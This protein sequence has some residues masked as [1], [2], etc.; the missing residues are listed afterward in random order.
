MRVLSRARD[1]YRGEHPGE[2]T[3]LPL[4]PV[5]VHPQA[6]PTR[7]PRSVLGIEG[8]DG[9]PDSTPSFRPFSGCHGL[10]STGGIRRDKREGLRESGRTGGGEDPLYVGDKCEHTVVRTDRSRETTVVVDCF[11]PTHDGTGVKFL[12]L[13]LRLYPLHWCWTGSFPVRVETVPGTTTTSTEP[14]HVVLSE[15]E[16]LP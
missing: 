2:W 16:R 1:P 7:S 11:R 8:D 4:L 5:R 13:W 12:L 10:V 3:G 14:F 6:R 9:V 15:P